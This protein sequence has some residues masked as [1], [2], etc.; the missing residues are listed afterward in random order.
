MAALPSFT[1]FCSLPRWQSNLPSVSSINFIQFTEVKLRS[2]FVIT[3]IPRKKLAENASDGEESDTEKKTTRKRAP[4]RRK[5][6]VESEV[7]VETPIVESSISNTDE[8]TLLPSESTEPVKPQRRGR[9]KE[10]AVASTSSTLEEEPEKK[11]TRRRRTKKKIDDTI[12]EG[13]E[14]E[15]SEPEEDTDNE[16]ELEIDATDADD[17]SFT[18]AW[19]PL[20]CCFGPVQHAFV[21][22]G[23]P[24]NRLIDHESH[25]RMKDALWTP[26]KFVRAPGSSAADVA[27]CLTKFGSNAAVMGKIGDDDFGQALLLHLNESRVQ[28]RSIRIDAKRT[29]AVSRMKMSKRGGLRTT[30]LVPCAED[31]L[32]KSEINIDVLK[33]AKIFYFNSFSLLDRKTKTSALQ[34]IKIS[35]QFG[36]LIFFDL[37]LPLPLWHSQEETY[38]IIQEALELADIVEVT[39]QE[40]E[41]LCGITPSER[42]DTNDNDRSKFVHYSRDM[43][44]PI[45][46]DNLELL[47]VTNGTSKIHYYTK[48]Q[49][50]SVLGT[51]DVP[52]TPF[53]SD[54]S[55]AGDGIVAGLMNKLIVQPHLMTDK[56][57]LVHSIDY[58]IN[59]GVSEQWMQARTRGYPPKPGMVDDYFFPDPNGFKTINEKA[60]RTLLNV[61]DDDSEDL[62]ITVNRRDGDDSEEDE[63][64]NTERHGDYDSED[65]DDMEI[66]DEEP[67]RKGRQA[68][69][70]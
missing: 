66:D 65:I 8:D 31:A 60:Y 56:E 23:R 43:V 32:K 35:K 17:I 54:M 55:A 16:K 1:Q 50:G 11:V 44:A 46:H 58:A 53:T 30:C 36:G 48:E 28:T 29:T 33:E 12:D 10:T 68:I 3:A 14:T 42:F 70:A 34:A 2:R 4:T 69:R 5:K 63:G 13:S 22:S 51:E 6:K 59:R 9:K 7:P 62:G 49:D 39:K 19:P 61:D 20:I 27:L 64:D 38:S 26:E 57:Y 37:N 45:L 24:A 52:I 25:E 67:V 40:L 41:F 47:F 15:L 21:P 18:Y